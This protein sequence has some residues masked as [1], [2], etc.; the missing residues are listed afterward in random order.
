MHSDPERTVGLFNLGAAT[1][2]WIAAAARKF[3]RNDHISTAHEIG[4]RDIARE[5]RVNH[6]KVVFSATTYLQMTSLGRAIR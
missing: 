2:Q 4:I 5:L 6:P 1:G 3:R